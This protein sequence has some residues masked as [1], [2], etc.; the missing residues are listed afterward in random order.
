MGVMYWRWGLAGVPTTC[1]KLRPCHFQDHKC[2]FQ[3]VDSQIST[4]QTSVVASIKGISSC[5][6]KHIP[7]HGYNH[8]STSPTTL[9]QHQVQLSLIHQPPGW[10]WQFQVLIEAQIMISCRPMRAGNVFPNGPSKGLAFEVRDLQVASFLGLRINKD[11]IPERA[12][13]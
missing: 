4:L 7:L 8:I 9:L 5:C 6:V 11:L 12:S 1:I 10:D 13:S 3:T 2:V